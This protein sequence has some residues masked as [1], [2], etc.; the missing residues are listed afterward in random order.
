[1]FVRF[2]IDRP[3]F[4]T[5]LSTVLVLAGGLAV[6]TL[7]LSQYPPVTPPT[8]QVDCNY[9]GAS[10][11]VVA[12]TIAAPIEQ[13]VNGVERMLYMTSQ[14]TSDGSYTLTVTFEIGTNLNLAQVLVQNRVNLALPNLPDVVQATGVTTRKR[15]AEIL[16]TVSLN[17]PEK[18]YD[19][20][21]LSN[22]AFTHVKDE[23][24]RLPGIS[25]VTLFGQRDYAI[26]VWLDPDRLAML[27]LSA[28]D[29]TKAIGEQNAQIPAGHIGQPPTPN[30][31]ALEYT[32]T[33]L[34]RL[35]TPEQFGEII[36]KS[37]ADKRIVR[38]KD[39]AKIE[40][41][42]RNAD[43]SM[44]FNRKPTIGLA[45]FLLTGA[46]SLEV[47]DA[48]KKE[49]KRLEEHFPADVS[50]DIGYDTTPFIRQS[51]YEVF[52]S[53]QDAIMLVAIVV[54]VF[55]QSWRASLIPLAAVPVAIIGTFAVMW[56]LGYSLNNL[57][58]F[59]LVL[60]V[61]IVVDD[62][63]VVV[64]AV[65]HHIEKGL[66]PREA[67]IQAMSEV[68][69]PI[70][71]VAAVLTAVFVPCVFLS[72]IVGQFFKQ[73]AVT[74]AVST[75]ISAFNSLTL[76]PALAA[77]LLRSPKSKRD[78]VTWLV[79][80]TLGWFFWLFNCGFDLSGRAYVKIVRMAIRMPVVLLVLYTGLTLTGAW[81]YQQL[82]SGFIPQQDKGYL[83]A[84]VA[85]PGCLIGGE[86]QESAG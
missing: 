50:Y 19:Q 40:L 6:G 69:G 1:M 14:S 51:I 57:T 8:I 63:I 15:S 59:G 52:N 77:L 43:V 10:A 83:I 60:A 12:Q 27:N 21:Y 86:K 46:N 76:S 54:L 9:P 80:N 23:L 53:L 48:V 41:G 84:S 34:G 31:Q 18:T 11:D 7:P 81:G 44:A 49:M 67:T 38:L 22:Y 56:S 25:D 32:L 13:Q 85:S 65:Q 72:G 75:L 17:S 82:P 24:S 39:V 4:A 3:I 78:P 36:V 58:L 73:F 71:A 66:A 47:G 28:T 45:V 79:D 62:A 33:A 20:L 16:M 64:E 55:L 61:G 74:I 30:G 2:F 68:T 42:A 37:T 35:K 70:V 26:R 29:I 5:V